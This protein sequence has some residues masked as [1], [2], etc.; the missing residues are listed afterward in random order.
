M[1]A[2]LPLVL[3]RPLLL[4]LLALSADL[5]CGC[6]SVLWEKET[7]AHYY[8]PACPAN[9]RLA[10]SEQRHDLLVQYNESKD[11][12][13]NTR[14]R[15]Y[16][17]EPNTLRVN[18]NQKP[19]F[20]SAK[21]IDGLIPIPVSEGAPNPSDSGLTNL[22]VMFSRGDDFFTLYSG[23]EK[24]DPYE[25]PVYSGSSQR[26]KQVLLTP[27]AVAVDATIIGAVIGYYSAPYLL[28]GLSR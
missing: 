21:T 26:V 15:C 27:F 22:Y 24:L 10:Y 9:L 7:F 2:L 11:G 25:L 28:A 13:P 6:T 16:W 19:H 18:R 8:R 5:S 17:L 14:P 4:A 20:V 23:T 1:K 3:H 12:N